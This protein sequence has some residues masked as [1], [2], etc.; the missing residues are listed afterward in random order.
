MLRVDLAPL[1]PAEYGRRVEVRDADHGRVLAGVEERAHASR[2]R[3]PRVGAAGGPRGDLLQQIAGE[4]AVDGAEE[5]ALVLEVV[6]ERAAGHVR[7][8]HDL[9]RP[10][11]GVAARGEQLARDAQQLGARRG[12]LLLPWHTV[13]MLGHTTC[14]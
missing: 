3:L 14:M 8:A 6:V 1:G 10:D 2:E 12:G 7:G 9:L 5:V 13:C 11:V 4:L